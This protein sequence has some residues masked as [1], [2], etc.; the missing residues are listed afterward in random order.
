MCGSLA[1][2][3]VN[4]ARSMHR[5]DAEDT[6]GIHDYPLE[7]H[8]VREAVEAKAPGWETVRVVDMD[9]TATEVWS[10]P[11]DEDLLAH[12]RVSTIYAPPTHLVPTSAEPKGLDKLRVDPVAAGDDGVRSGASRSGPSQPGERR[13]GVQAERAATRPSRAWR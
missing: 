10:A 2:Y 11:D 7:H 9:A 12:S 8:L 5:A 3:G 6:T 1:V 4:A 13:G